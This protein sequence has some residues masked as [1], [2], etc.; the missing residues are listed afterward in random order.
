[1]TQNYKDE[2]M[3][4]ES[5]SKVDGAELDLRVLAQFVIRRKWL[6]VGCV[7]L[8][9][10]GFGLAAFLVTPIY[11][12][13]AILMPASSERSSTGILGSALGQLGGLASLAGINIG[14]GDT[15]TVESLEVMRSREFTEQFIEDN[16]LLPKL[17]PRQWNASAKKWTVE[18]DRHTLAKGSRLFRK[19]VFDVIQNKKDGVVTVQ[20]DWKNRFEAAAWANDLVQRLNAE[21]RS[22]AI[23]TADASIGYL[24]SELKKTTDIGTQQ[25]INRLIEVQIRQR[26]L[27][28]VSPQYS[29]RVIDHALPADADD[30]FFPKK[31]LFFVLGPLSGIVLAALCLLVLGI[32]AK[33]HEIGISQRP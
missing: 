14:S 1:M 3:T 29:F 2:G 31:A 20:I 4:I 7:V 27:A 5:P 13:E 21:M 6:V 28:T 15:E 12:S 23:A 18:D 16:G 33:W 19:K 22:R 8:C 24:N 17:F 11:R 10:V 9:T 30:P 26:M 32:L 25:A